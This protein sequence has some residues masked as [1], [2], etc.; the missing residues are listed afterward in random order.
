MVGTISHP[1][2]VNHRVPFCPV[3]VMLTHI[4]THDCHLCINTNPPSLLSRRMKQRLLP[5]AAAK[6]VN[7][8]NAVFMFSAWR[9]LYSTSNCLW[10]DGR[11]LQ[12]PGFHLFYLSRPSV[13]L[14]IQKGK[15]NSF[16]WYWIPQ[17]KPPMLKPLHYLPKTL[18]SW[19]QR[20]T[21]KLQIHY[22]VYPC[23]CHI[24]HI[25]NNQAS[26]TLKLF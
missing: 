22:P 13:S 20:K 4:H 25:L 23:H 15:A 11:I 16:S 26:C 24:L 9:A 3:S 12:P 10:V 7:V 21:W 19:D 14:F 6:Y 1:F 5:M 18:Y 2:S 8:S 17:V